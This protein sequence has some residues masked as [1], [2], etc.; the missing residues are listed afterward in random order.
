MLV[1][2][3]KASRLPLTG[4]PYFWHVTKD[5]IRT[6]ATSIGV[7]QVHDL[8][9]TSHPQALD[10]AQLPCLSR[11]GDGGWAYDDAG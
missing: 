2:R 5:R 1:K 6:S 8:L 3:S 7:L 9:F 4:Q 11:D 10:P